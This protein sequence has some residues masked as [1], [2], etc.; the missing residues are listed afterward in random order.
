MNYAAENWALHTDIDYRS[1]HRFSMRIDATQQKIAFLTFIFSL[2]KLICDIHFYHD[3]AFT[4]KRLIC[5]S[6]SRAPDS[7]SGFPCERHSSLMFDTVVLQWTFLS[8]NIAWLLDKRKIKL[9]E[10]ALV[11]NVIRILVIQTSTTRLQSITRLLNAQWLTKNTEWGT[12]STIH[13]M[14]ILV[15][16]IECI[17]EVKTPAC[18]RTGA[19]GGRGPEPDRRISA[20]WHFRLKSLPFTS[21]PK[22]EVAYITRTGKI[23]RSCCTHRDEVFD[24]LFRENK[25]NSV[26]N[27]DVV[28]SI[29][30]QIVIYRI[31]LCFKSN[32]VV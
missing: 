17:C 5:I 28:A 13:V 10:K 23:T 9:I 31:S 24:Y 8:V 12:H 3:T 18:E 30:L 25:R 19:G 27:M 22:N 26:L 16:G 29:I 21:F 32:I 2:Q 4:M 7:I 14:S 1:I 6:P 20:N 11:T 15:I